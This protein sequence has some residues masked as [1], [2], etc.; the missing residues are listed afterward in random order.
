MDTLIIDSPSRVNK[1]LTRPE[2]MGETYFHAACYN[3]QNQQY[4]K[5]KQLLQHAYTHLFPST[6][7]EMKE[8]S[9]A[10]EQASLA[11]L[12]EDTDIKNWFGKYY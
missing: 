5:A 6:I 10:F 1:T 3:A 9:D 11:F 2:N 8:V 4:S 7:A 12:K